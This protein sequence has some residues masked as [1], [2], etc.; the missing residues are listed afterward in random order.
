MERIAVLLA[1]VV[2][3]GLLVW[4][5]WIPAEWRARPEPVIAFPVPH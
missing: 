1:V 3:F 4:P 5:G 2:T